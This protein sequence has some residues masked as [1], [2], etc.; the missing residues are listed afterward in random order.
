MRFAYWGKYQLLYF[1]F[2]PLQIPVSLGIVLNP[3]QSKGH[4]RHIRIIV[5]KPRIEGEGLE[6][7]IIAGAA[8]K[9]FDVIV[10]DFVVNLCTDFF[11]RIVFGFCSGIYKKRDIAFLLFRKRVIMVAGILKT[12]T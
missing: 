4:K 6:N 10:F 8:P 11:C 1:G 2:Q 3:L 12:Y 9:I 5:I 7:I